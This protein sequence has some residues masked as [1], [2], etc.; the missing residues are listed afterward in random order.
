LV[1]LPLI[2]VLCW[3]SPWIIL[4]LFPL[5]IVLIIWSRPTISS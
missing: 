5:V 2:V 3:W 4:L 1:I